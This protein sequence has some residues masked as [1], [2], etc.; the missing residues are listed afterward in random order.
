MHI[1]EIFGRLSD[2][3]QA[4]L[5]AHLEGRHNEMIEGIVISSSA[6]QDALETILNSENIHK[7][8]GKPRFVYIDGGFIN[9]ADVSRVEFDTEPYELDS[10]G[11]KTSYNPS[12][13]AEVAGEWLVA[14]VYF[15]GDVQKYVGET[16]ESLQAFM[17]Q[18]MT[19]WSIKP[20]QYDGDEEVQE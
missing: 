1:S 4:N 17:A 10:N 15:T 13:K 3:A 11:D 14:T 12:T 18:V 16:A 9:M 20:M 7:L 6:I 2:E 19:M 8:L 5:Q